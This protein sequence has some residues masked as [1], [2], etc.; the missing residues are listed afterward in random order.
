MTGPKIKERLMTNV[1]AYGIIEQEDL[2]LVVEAVA[3]ASR[4]YTV[5]YK[6]LSAV[7]SPIDTK[8][9][10]RTDKDVNRHNEVLRTVM[11]HG[12]GRTVVP[13]SFGMAFKNERTLKGVMRGARRAFRKALND[14]EGTVE[15]G[16]KLIASDSA[17]LN[18]EAIRDDVGD[19][20]GPHYVSETDNDLFSERLLLNK[21]Y[22]V[23]R[24]GRDAFDDA[25]DKIEAEYEDVLT[26]QYTGPWAPY[27]FVDIHIG[28]NKGGR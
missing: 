15:L 26:V 21:S 7:V 13:M 1:Y 4:V 2:E 10:E 9:P 20:L 3:G 12:D 16:V 8:D 25:I 18:G 19:R 24:D 22:L 14:I 6:T 28:A 5:D 27:N 11:E 23:E 17:D